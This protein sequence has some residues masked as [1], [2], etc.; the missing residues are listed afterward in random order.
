MNR[1]ENGEEKGKS[2]GQMGKGWR[3]LEIGMGTAEESNRTD[4][5]YKNSTRN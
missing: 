4:M 3:Q 5:N 1:M 2:R